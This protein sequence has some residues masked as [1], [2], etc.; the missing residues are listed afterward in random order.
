MVPWFWI[1]P[2]FQGLAVSETGGQGKIEL[3]VSL[4]G[5]Y[6]VGRTCDLVGYAHLLYKHR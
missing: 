6:R 5:S 4:R 3:T 2:E 1:K